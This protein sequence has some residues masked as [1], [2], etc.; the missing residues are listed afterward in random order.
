MKKIITLLCCLMY[1]YGAQFFASTFTIEVPQALLGQDSSLMIYMIDNFGHQQV[2]KCQVDSRAKYRTIL[3]NELELT[4]IQ[5]AESFATFVDVTN[6]Q[7]ALQQDVVILHFEL[8]SCVR[9][10]RILVV[11]NSFLEDNPF[12]VLTLSVQQ[13]KDLEN[14]HHSFDEF[15]EDLDPLF[16]LVENVD[17]QAM[18]ESLSAQ[19]QTMS[20]LEQCKLYAEIYMLMQYG[21]VKRAMHNMSSWFSNLKA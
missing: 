16:A 18:E 13:N 2:G 10:L 4:T 11:K 17:A 15:E 7:A 20:T 19:H 21:K 1:S 8:D 14:K 6:S 5:E 12:D 9:I 3:Q